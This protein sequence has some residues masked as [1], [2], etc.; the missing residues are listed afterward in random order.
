MCIYSAIYRQ[1][2]ISF[3]REDLFQEKDQIVVK[4]P[5]NSDDFNDRPIPA[6]IKLKDLFMVERQRNE[7]IAIF[8]REKKKKTKAKTRKK[9]IAMRQI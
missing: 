1:T 8:A 9:Q 4:N 2:E 3:R 7:I 5:K 6:K